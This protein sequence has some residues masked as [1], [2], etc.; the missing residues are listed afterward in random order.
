MEKD[1]AKIIVE[2]R[3][4]KGMTQEELATKLMITPQAVSKWERGAGLPDATLFPA[5]AEALGVSIGVLF[6]EEQKKEEATTAQTNAPTLPKTFYGLPLVASHGGMG[7]YSN[8]KLK[9]IEEDTVKFTDGSTATFSNQNVSNRGAGEIRFCGELEAPQNIDPTKTSYARQFDDIKSLK[10]SNSY[11]CLISVVPSKD[12]ITRVTASGTAEFISLIETETE[13]SKL[14]VKVKSPKFGGSSFEKVGNLTVE[15]GFEQGEKLEIG[16]AGSGSVSNR[17]NFITSILS[18]AG[19]GAIQTAD[20][21]YVVAKIAGSGDIK[22]GSAKYSS[23]LKIAGSG[24]ISA[25][26]LGADRASINIAGSGDVKC[27]SAADVTIAISGSGDISVKDIQKAINATVTGSGD[28]ACG[29]NV[30]KLTLK[31]TGSGDF[32]AKNLCADTADINM[33]GSGDA[34]IGRIISG[35]TE[36]L[37]KRSRLNVLKRG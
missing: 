23:T 25:D 13:Q 20:S 37:S 14:T 10:I 16:I 6:G 26:S 1:F 30:E 4:A 35:S 34:T 11:K 17:I 29:G 8:K 9:T 32:D 19:S 15:A 22:F 36:R 2:L 28:V 24:D 31:I 3:R 7:C 12:K 5:L 33:N 18:I 21:D 27:N